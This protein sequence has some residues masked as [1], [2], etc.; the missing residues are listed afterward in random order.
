M[1]NSACWSSSKTQLGAEPLVVVCAMFYHALEEG[2]E[3][4]HILYLSQPGRHRE[5][6]CTG[7]LGEGE[8][9]GLG[10]QTK[11]EHFVDSPCMISSGKFKLVIN[12]Q[13]VFIFSQQCH[14]LLGEEVPF[15]PWEKASKGRTHLWSQGD[16]SI[17]WEGA[18]VPGSTLP[19]APPAESLPKVPT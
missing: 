9:G 11:G 8:L 10:T 3:G 7:C 18:E 19:P 15:F 16:S 14:G 4:N 5:T 13:N 2:E 17:T 1:R 12:K 6:S